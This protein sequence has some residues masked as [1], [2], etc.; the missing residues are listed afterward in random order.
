MG[1]RGSIEVG[2]RDGLASREEIAMHENG[3]Q[4][5]SSRLP[6]EPRRRPEGAKQRKP[7][8]PI[9]TAGIGPTHKDPNS[10]PPTSGGEGGGVTEAIE[11]PSA[12]GGDEA[13]VSLA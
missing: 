4:E 10:I 1:P 8:G 12:T 13:E 11:E 7:E 3:S 2:L 9:E 5:T 6:E